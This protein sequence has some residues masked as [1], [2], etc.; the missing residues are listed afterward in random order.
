MGRP[1]VV[2]NP[3]SRTVS[4]PQK[5]TLRSSLML[6]S[7]V[8]N[9]PGRTD[10]DVKNYW[11]TKL[12]KRLM[13]MGID[14]VT[15]KPVSQVLSEFRNISGRGSSCELFVMNFK[16][17]PSNNSVLTHSNSA[18][19]MI[20]NTT[21]HESYYNSSPM[22]ITNPLHS[23][24]LASIN[25]VS[26]ASTQVV[27]SSAASSLTFGQNGNVNSQA[28]CSSKNI[29]TKASGKYHSASYFVDKDQEILSQFLQRLNDFDY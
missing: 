10:N 24:Y 15:H 21:I 20:R 22:I 9:L 17:E 2:T 18:W 25:Q 5:K 12:K 19:E 16:T 7:M 27:G 23:I 29:A 28:E 11:N 26:Q 8:N 6:Q 4:G 14:P 1:P 13:K 3:T